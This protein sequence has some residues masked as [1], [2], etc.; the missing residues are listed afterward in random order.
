[1]EQ[2]E[3]DKR[4]MAEALRL[5]GIAANE[6]EIPIGAVIVYNDRIIGKGYNL[7]QKLHDVTAHAE[8][9][10]ITAAA[11]FVNGKYLDECT[12]YVTI[13]PCI[14]CAGAL[15]W[16]Q[17]GR[18][19]YGAGDEKRG[20]MKEGRQLLHPKTE[21]SSGIMAEECGTLLSDFFKKLRKSREA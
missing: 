7:T 8:M 5:A 9:Q 4:F 3:K 11:N 20:F 16:A 1:M 19:V 14:M 6:E 12:I 21:L 13:E 17:I 15:F 10:A 18:L 2:E